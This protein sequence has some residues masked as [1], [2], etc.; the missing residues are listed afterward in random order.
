MKINKLKSILFMVAVVSCF[1]LGAADPVIA[2]D[3]SAEPPVL[4]GEVK[5]CLRINKA[6]NAVRAFG[7][8]ILYPARKLSFK[9]ALQAD[10]LKDG[11]GF[12]GAREVSPGRIRLG[13]FEPGENH[14]PANAAGVLAEL[15]FTV[16]EDDPTPE[17]RITGL[18]DD[19]AGWVSTE[20]KTEAADLDIVRCP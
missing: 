9:K 4:S 13:G 19:M 2:D 16:I 10:L 5:W 1:S 14:I 7:L 15:T 3:S 8:E 6:P 18:K 20:E 12:F 17:F 11:A